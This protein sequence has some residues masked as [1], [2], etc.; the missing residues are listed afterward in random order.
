MPPTTDRQTEG[1]HRLHS[2]VRVLLSPG[3]WLVLFVQLVLVS[4]MQWR[5]PADAPALT[6]ALIL[7]LTSAVLMLFFYLQAGAFHALTLGRHTLSVGEIAR[8]GKEVFATFIWLTLK[9]GLLLAAVLYLLVFMALAITGAEL[10]SIVHTYAAYFSPLVGIMAFI[11]V[12]WLP[13]V[14]VRREFRLLPSLKAALA[15]AW[16]RR[17]HS[18][19]LVLLVL[20]PVMVSGMLPADAPE[21]LEFLVSVAGGVMGWIAY[22]YCVEVLQESL[23]NASHNAS[24]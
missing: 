8:A 5:A 4:F 17:S 1:S 19:F 23:L 3:I 18:A 12:Y 6:S 13:F 14:F 10:K 20:T 11:F 7:L 9:A 15:T 21:L 2:T 16:T 24:A 22:I